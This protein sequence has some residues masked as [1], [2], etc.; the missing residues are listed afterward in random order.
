MDLG[1]ILV[2]TPWTHFFPLC[3]SPS[4][5]QWRDSLHRG[6]PLYLSHP[7][8]PSKNNPS[9]YSTKHRFLYLTIHFFTRNLKRRVQC[10]ESRR[11][12]CPPETWLLHLTGL[13]NRKFGKHG[14]K[15]LGLV[16]L[17]IAKS[18]I[19][20]SANELTA[21]SFLEGLHLLTAHFSYQGALSSWKILSLQFPLSGPGWPTSPPMCCK[22]CLSSKW[23][24]FNYLY[25]FQAF[26][27]FFFKPC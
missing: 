20:I 11:V 27:S 7:L 5:F 13:W 16:G 8:L 14:K 1:V 15:S 4:I 19:S 23:Q 22:S 9:L 21:Q 6:D 2:R 10:L 3:S 12:C 25:R 24:T 26:F 18:F 17:L